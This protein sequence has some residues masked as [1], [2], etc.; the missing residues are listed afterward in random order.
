MSEDTGPQAAARRGRGLQHAA[1]SHGRPGVG[2]HLASALLPL[3]PGARYLK[4][5]YRHQVD[6]LD[7]FVSTLYARAP[8][9]KGR[10][11]ARCFRVAAQ[12]GWVLPS[13]RIVAVYLVQFGT[14]AD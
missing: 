14:A 4:G 7:Q 13:G 5:R 6:S 9:E 12:Q 11:V 2:V 8:F 3:P 1:A 10:L